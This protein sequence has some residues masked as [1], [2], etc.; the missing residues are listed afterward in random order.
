MRD[1]VV[2]LQSITST[3]A[4]GS[5][6]ILLPSPI[7]TFIDSTVP[8]I[9]LPAMACELFEASLGLVWNESLN[10]YLVDQELH[11]N[12]LNTDPQ[13][14]FRIGNDKTSKSTVDINLPYASFDLM[15]TPPLFPEN[16]SYFP[17]RRAKSDDQLTLGRV[18]LQE[19]YVSHSFHMVA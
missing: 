10:L 2:G 3:Y 7:L 8:Y 15:A 5:S 16:T 12:L 17:I 1:L 11:Q 14:T 13:F 19:A 18:F 6:S 9:Y 4:N